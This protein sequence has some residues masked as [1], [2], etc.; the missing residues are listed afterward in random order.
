MYEARQNKEKVSR[1]IDAAGGMTRQRVILKSKVLQ[2]EP[3]FTYT[4]KNKVKPDEKLKE[5]R[6]LRENQG[7]MMRKS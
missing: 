5:I 3:I 4:A 2:K 1:R 7:L 6:N